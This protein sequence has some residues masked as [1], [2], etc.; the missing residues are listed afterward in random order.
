M[1]I[2]EFF[3]PL[4][5]WR[6]HPKGVLLLAVPLFVIGFGSMGLRAILEYKYHDNPWFLVIFL[7][8]SFLGYAAIRPAYVLIRDMEKRNVN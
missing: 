4:W 3:E 1:S 6:K 8:G 2:K 5:N 7:G